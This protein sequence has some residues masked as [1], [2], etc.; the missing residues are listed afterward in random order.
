MGRARPLGQ[1]PG[2]RASRW[3]LCPGTA[4]TRCTKATSRRACGMG[5]GSSRA[6]RRPLSTASTRATGTRASGVATAS[7]RTAIG[8][9]SPAAPGPPHRVRA[10]CQRVRSVPRSL[11]DVPHCPRAP[12]LVLGSGRGGP[13]LCDRRG[14]PTLMPPREEEEFLTPPSGHLRP[15]GLSDE[16]RGPLPGTAGPACSSDLTPAVTP[17]H[18][19][20]PLTTEHPHIP[21]AHADLHGFAHL[22]MAPDSICPFCHLPQEDCQGALTQAIALPPPPSWGARPHLPR[23]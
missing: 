5:L 22:R 23:V 8:E 4:V 16:A 20:S 9:R 21:V 17:G 12:W 19:A 6:P 11:S 7:G 1:A 15:S 10:P 13:G 18:P 14:L 2:G 3:S